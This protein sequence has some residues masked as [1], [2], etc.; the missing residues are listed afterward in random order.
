MV[1]GSPL[2]IPRLIGA[3]PRTPILAMRNAIVRCARCGGEP[4]GCRVV[5][6][7]IDGVHGQD[8][9]RREEKR[10]TETHGFTF[11]RR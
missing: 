10:W 6:W 2:V 4:A 3:W 11:D 5:G 8:D 9:V 7:G 1:N